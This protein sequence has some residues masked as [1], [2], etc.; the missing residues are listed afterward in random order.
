MNY[1]QKQIKYITS[2]KIINKEKKRKQIWH[3]PP[4]I[5]QDIINVQCENKFNDLAITDKSV[6]MPT[7]KNSRVKKMLPEE[8]AMCKM[9]IV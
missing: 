5:A 7:K 4:Y 2:N 8:K 6:K 9:C 1:Q 3:W